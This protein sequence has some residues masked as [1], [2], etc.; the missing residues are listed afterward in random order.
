MKHFPN[1]ISTHTTNFLSLSFI[2]LPTTRYFSSPIIVKSHRGP[3]S[4]E[5]I[6]RLVIVRIFDDV[7]QVSARSERKCGYGAGRWQWWLPTEGGGIGGKRDRKRGARDAREDAG[8]QSV[9]DSCRGVAGSISVDRRHKLFQ[10]TQSSGSIV[11][12][13][14]LFVSS[15]VS[16]A[17]VAASAASRSRAR[18]NSPPPPSR[19]SCRLFSRVSPLFALFLTATLSLVACCSTSTNKQFCNLSTFYYHQRLL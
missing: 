5:I 19:S 17:P 15:R 2:R 14:L 11:C 10:W 13:F 18:I 9:G 16:L 6:P 4:R 3:R 8:P 12:P 7:P 1:K